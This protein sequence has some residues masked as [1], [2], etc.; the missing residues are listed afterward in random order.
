M[1][2]NTIKKSG[3]AAI[4]FCLFTISTFS[5]NQTQQTSNF[6]KDVQ[7]GGGVGLNLGNGFFSG[8]LAPNALYRFSPYVSGGVGLN[9]QY[10]S[11]R[12]VF[13]SR[14]LGGSVIGL[15]NPFREIQLSTEFEQLHVSQS[16]ERNINNQVIRNNDTN[17]WYP[18]LFLGVGYRSQN[19]TFGIRYDVL[20]DRN[21]SIQ[22]EA[23]MPFIRFWF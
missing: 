15:F 16:V 3:L 21:R 19:V 4:L 6:W 7:F 14:V 17:Y 23:W 12:D 11:Q 5:Q 22:P 1:C 9:F 20:Y 8:V 13:K 10:T 18:A 2:H